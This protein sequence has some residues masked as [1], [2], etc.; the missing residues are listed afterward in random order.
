[1][2]RTKKTAV[3]DKLY[4]VLRIFMVLSAICMFVPGLNPARMSGMINKNMSF[5]TSAVSYSALEDTFGRA[6]TKGWV[7][8]STLITITVSSAIACLGIAALAVGGCMSLGSLKLKRLG[9]KISIV[10]SSVSIVSMLFLLKA[11][12]DFSASEKLEKIKPM[13]PSGFAVVIS[14][15]A[16]CL[17]LSII[18]MGLLPK[19]GKEEKYEMQSKYK[20]FLLF[21]PFILMIFVFSYLP[22]WGWRY[23]FFDYTAGQALSADNFVGFK[24]FTQ[25]FQNS[26]TKSDIIRVLRNT[27]AMSFLGIG[28]SWLAMAFAI[29]LSE[30][31][32][33][34]F[35]RVVQ[36]LTT[37]PNFIS[38][39][40]V[41]AV[42]FAIF[43]SDGF[44]NSIIFG[45]EGPN[46]LMS[47]NFTWL[48]MLAWGTWKG[49][50]WSAI[51]YI[52]AIAGIDQQLYEAASIDGAGRFQR[53]WNITV[54]GLMPT[55]CVLLLLAVAGIL[56]NGMDQ[57][58]V[59]DN[60]N[61]RNAIEVLDLYVYKIGINKGQ[62]PLATVVG[63]VKSIVSVTL[64]FGAN[65]ISKALRGESIV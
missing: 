54:P 41:Y 39:V 35:R 18:I 37:I 57:Y 9:N 64:L 28:T 46:Y 15:I 61:N 2:E 23:A 59:F 4:V 32:S 22:L 51:I 60:A 24:W 14:L 1:M 29:F 49:L 42:A 26:A 36:T 53:M 63:M 21:M 30:M 25:L 17:V 38:W 52:A 31:K 12:S 5:F 11:H 10:A 19:A 62:V 55:Y 48:K 45:G 33:H 43:S 7:E 65:R 40:L 13:M 44:V 8:Q 27:L 34:K 20:L 6:L 58:L 3:A 47:A 16:I 50:G 56:S